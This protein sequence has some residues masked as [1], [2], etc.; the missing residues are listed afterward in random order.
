M[1]EK[2]KSAIKKAEEKISQKIANRQPDAPHKLSLSFVIAPRNKSDFFTDFLHE[3]EINAEYVLSASGTASNDTLSELGV[4][5]SDKAVIIG[6]VRNDMIKPALSGLEEKFRTLRGAK[7]VAFVSPMTSLIG[8]AV[9]Q[10]L[11]N[12]EK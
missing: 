11:C 10:F 5:S 4:V 9:Y 12:K 6:V 2:I 1:G 3:Y 8:V 7:G